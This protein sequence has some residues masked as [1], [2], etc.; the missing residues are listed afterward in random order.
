MYDVAPPL[1]L[2]TA[3]FRKC[4]TATLATPTLQHKVHSSVKLNSIRQE[5]PLIFSCNYYSMV[6][7]H[8]E[9]WAN[10]ALKLAGVGATAAVN[11]GVIGVSLRLN[12]EFILFWY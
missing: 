3:S 5:G 7:R 1:C 10:H 12:R 8:P 11:E 9:H 2:E 4:P 6:S